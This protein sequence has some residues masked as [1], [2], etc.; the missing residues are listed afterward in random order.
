[1]GEKII[2]LLHEA[3]FRVLFAWVLLKMLK[4]HAYE[5]IFDKTGEQL[6]LLVLRVEPN[7]LA[8]IWSDLG[9]HLFNI[10]HELP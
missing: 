6:S 10:G 1:M 3:Y 9:L 5:S 8:Q 2:D 4:G 7:Y